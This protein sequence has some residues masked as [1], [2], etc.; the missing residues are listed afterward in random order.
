MGAGWFASRVSSGNINIT[1]TTHLRSQ[2]SANTPL[3]QRGRQR[4][5][6]RI[7]AITYRTYSGLS[8]KVGEF[9]V[10]IGTARKN[11]RFANC[12]G[13]C[14]H[15]SIC[16]ILVCPSTVDPIRNHL[17]ICNQATPTGIMAKVL[18]LKNRFMST[19]LHG[20]TTAVVRR[21]LEREHVQGWLRSPQ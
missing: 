19:V 11:C 4:A 17:L 1:K 2:Y 18:I 5:S 20:G 7:T 21:E 3:G 10:H 13:T 15:I 14:P 12:G 16:V 8:S 9:C 6:F